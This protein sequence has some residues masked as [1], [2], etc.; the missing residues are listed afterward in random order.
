[1]QELVFTV[2]NFFRFTV[3]DTRDVDETAMTITSHLFIDMTWSDQRIST[4]ENDTSFDVVPVSQ[5]Y[6]KELWTP[7]TYILNLIKIE[8]K[9][10]KA[11]I[12]LA[13]VDCLLFLRDGSHGLQRGISDPGSKWNSNIEDSVQ[14]SYHNLL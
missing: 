3:T 9:N 7:P 10:C 2:V 4:I 11:Y 14:V 8:G 5:D 13:R 12:L 6:L 1:M